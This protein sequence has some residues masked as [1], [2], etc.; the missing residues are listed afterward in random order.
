MKLALLLVLVVGCGSSKPKET[1]ATQ[2]ASTSEPSGAAPPITPVEPAA[3][4]KGVKG[5]YSCFSYASKSSTM[6]RH[7]C[8]RGDDCASYLD[9]AKSLPGLKDFSGCETVATV[10]CFHQSGSKDDPDGQDICQPTLD[11]CKVGRA[12]VMRAKMAVDSECSQH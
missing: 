1:T 5:P 9:Q 4:A 12:D 8:A 11:E 3:A 10:F 2:P 6:K 7:G